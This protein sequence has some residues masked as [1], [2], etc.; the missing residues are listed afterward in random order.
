MGMGWHCDSY[1]VGS[2]RRDDEIR[3]AASHLAQAEMH[4]DR[5]Y[6]HP[7]LHRC[8]L[9]TRKTN[10]SQ[11]TSINPKLERMLSI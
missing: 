10:R 4:R 6:V 8:L 11:S 3:K 9:G 1:R 5:W 7:R 2:C